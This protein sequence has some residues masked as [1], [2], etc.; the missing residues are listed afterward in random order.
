MNYGTWY[1]QG[2]WNGMLFFFVNPRCES[3]LGIKSFP[4]IFE[5][6]PFV[7]VIGCMIF[8]PQFLNVQTVFFLVWHDSEIICS[9]LNLWQHS[10]NAFFVLSRF[11]LW[12]HF[13]KNYCYN[14]KCLDSLSG[15]VSLAFLLTSDVIYSFWIDPVQFY[16]VWLLT[17][18]LVMLQA[19]CNGFK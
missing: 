10:A 1:I 14:N 2:F 7:I 18:S 17:K 6:G 16:Q 5:G 9:P 3:H 13:S 8:L 4:Y 12:Y 19:S 15:T 11:F